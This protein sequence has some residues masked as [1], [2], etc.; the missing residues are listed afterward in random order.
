MERKQILI[1]AVVVG[2]LL[3]LAVGMSISQAQEPEPS[4]ESETGIQGEV[5]TLAAA[6]VVS[7]AISYQGVLKENGNPVNGTRAITFTL[8]SDASCSTV[9][10]TIVKS[11][12]PITDGL[13]SVKLSVDQSDFNGQRLW[14]APEVNGTA[15]G[16]QEIMAAPYALSLRP[17]AIISDTSS[18]AVLNRSWTTGSPIV[19]GHKAGI[20]GSADISGLWLGS[21]Y[22]VYGESENGYGV[23]GKSTN[24]TAVYGDGDVKQTLSGN[25]LVKAAVYAD[26][27]GGSSSIDR[28]FN[29]VN[30]TDIA[31]S[32]WIGVGTCTIDVGFDLSDRYWVAT[33]ANVF[34]NDHVITCNKS[35]T[36]DQNLLC[37]SWDTGSDSYSSTNITVLIY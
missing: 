35:G 29:N 16:C 15:I 19:W 33:I 12:V 1:S 14:L 18:R 13:F 5:G 34:A 30:T 9:E 27:D 31:I 2:L 6:D 23:Y 8:Y 20:Y 21:T 25:G 32:D 11:S 24:G 28:F 10:D 4:G 37:T 3:A 17:G 7:N 36:D 22:G 26:C